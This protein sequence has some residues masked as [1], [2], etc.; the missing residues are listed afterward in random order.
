[1]PSSYL[2]RGKLTQAFTIT[3]KTC[4]VTGAN[5]GIG[6]V[7]ARE[8]A[9][10]G[11]RI[12]L[13]C[14]DG[15]KG[16]T[17]LDRIRLETDSQSVELMIANLAS[18]NSVRKLVTDFKLAHKN[19]HVLVNN[20]GLILGKRKVTLDGLEETFQVNYLSHFLLTYLMLDVLKASSPSRIVNISSSAH[21]NGRMNFEDLQQEKGYGAM[22]AYCQSKLAQVLFTRELSERLKESGVCVNSVHP[23]AVRTKWGDEAGALGIGIRLA[24]PFMAS[25]EKGAQTPIYVA[26]SPELEGVSGKYFSNKKIKEPSSESKSD[27]EAKKLWEISSSLSH[28]V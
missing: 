27:E 18:L 25:A 19:L 24:R 4:L 20:A 14:R 28:I 23:G 22:K 1:M 10:M 7:I 2:E 12:V 21:Y 26:T 8:L 13:V 11:G 6:F 17:A 16:K 5:S 15:S 9:M 3:E